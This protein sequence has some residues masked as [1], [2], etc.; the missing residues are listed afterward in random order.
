MKIK[1]IAGYNETFEKEYK[2]FDAENNLSCIFDYIFQY[3]E[4]L[5]TKIVNEKDITKRQMMYAKIKHIEKIL[6]YYKD[7]S[8]FLHYEATAL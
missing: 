4:E 3:K 2:E 7:L 1:I 6:V 5:Y 8:T